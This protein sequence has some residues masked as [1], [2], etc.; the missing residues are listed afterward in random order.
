LFI[1]DAAHAMSPIGGVGVNL[2]IQDAVATAN[3]L[4]PKLRQG[5]VTPDDLLAVQRRREPPTIRTQRLQL[6]MQNR[7][8]S[9]VL[10]GSV[11][12]KPPFLLKLMQWVPTLQRI[13]ARIIGMGF[14]PEHIRH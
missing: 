13:P 1:G 9:P 12:P 6:F 14:Q 4:I 7:I 11:Q 5:V 3:I 2:A 8:V 10:S